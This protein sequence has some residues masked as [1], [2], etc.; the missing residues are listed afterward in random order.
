MRRFLLALTVSIAA[1]GSAACGGTSQTV[2]APS[3][4]KCP[5]TASANPTSFGPSGG[6]G[7]LTVSTN[8]ECEWNASATG[9]WIQLSGSTNGQGDARIP[10]S[11][12]PNA[13]PTER[14][15]AIAVADQQVPI[16]QQAGA[17]TFRVSPVSA[18]IP[19]SGG[20]RTVSVTA[21]SGECAWTARADAA[22]LVIVEGSQGSGSGNVVVEARPTSGPSRTGTLVVAG[23]TVTVAQGQGC[24]TAIAPENQ[25]VGASGGSGTIAVNTAPGC[26]WSAQSDVPWLTIVSGSSGNGPGMVSFT[27]A[28]WNGPTRTGTIHVDEHVF[29]VTQT[30]GCS[31]T[32]EPESQ[33]LPGAGGSGDVTVRTAPGCPWSAAANVP[34]LSVI[35]DAAGS[36]EGH[37]QFTALANSGPAR[38]GTLTIAGRNFRVDQAS[39]CSV[40]LFASNTD[41]AAG[42]G[43]GSV[44]VSVSAGCAWTATTSALWMHI[45]S[46]SSGTGGGTIA[47]TVDPNTGASARDADITVNGQSVIIHQPAGCSYGLSATGGSVPAGGG[48]GSVTVTSGGGCSWTA[49]TSAGWVHI[50]AGASGTGTGTVEY[51]ADPNTGDA[52]TAAL[53]IAG[54]TYTVSQSGSCTVSIDPSSQLIDAG[55]GS[56]TFSVTTGASCAWTAASSD[57]WLHI[58]SGASGT[59]N[60]TVAFPADPNSGPARSGTIVAGGQTFT[61][62]QNSGCSIAISPSG[63]SFGPGGGNGSISV[64]AGAG[65]TWNA[66]VTSG[67]EWISITSGSGLGDG[68][69]Q[70]SVSPNSGAARSGTIVVGGQAFAVTQSGV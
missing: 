57:G 24:S 29:T 12:A 22:W 53:T 16:A 31:Y 14:R 45:T 21:S 26:K 42:G 15:A 59:G 65:C 36:G 1:A 27:A 4:V 67:A 64:A 47:Y 54:I 37:V 55:G 66:T 48:T 3:T 63:Q 5:V 8:R 34:W 32:I 10:F 68:S 56:G 50:T 39:G 23:Y 35:G 17:C 40:S 61:A 70:F 30:E 2:T 13:Q 6:S 62:N 58:T 43:S 18:T 9:G 46:G 20:R 44:T 25:T 69:V 60:G 38:S 28:G 49:S 33:A 41:V 7:T 11:V 52:R 19:S 51:L